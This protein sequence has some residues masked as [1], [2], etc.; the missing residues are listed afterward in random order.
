MLWTILGDHFQVNWRLI[1]ELMNKKLL[2]NFLRKIVKSCIWMIN[3]IANCAII[4]KFKDLW[5]SDSKRKRIEKKKETHKTTFR[6]KILIKL[7]IDFWKKEV[8]FNQ[9]VEVE[10]NWCSKEFLIPNYKFSKRNERNFDDSLKECVDKKWKT[11]TKYI[12]IK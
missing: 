6:S 2:T 10:F 4:Q 1:T 8:K 9:S 11:T 7:P 3:D 12:S 5:K